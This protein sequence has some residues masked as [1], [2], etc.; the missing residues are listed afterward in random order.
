MTR[1]VLDVAIWPKFGNPSIY[2]REVIIT[3]IEGWSWFKFNNFELAL[4][5]ALEILHQCGKKVETKSRKVFRA[6]SYICRSS[7]R[8][9]RRGRPFCSPPSWIGLNQ[10][11]YRVR[12]DLT[13]VYILA[14][15]LKYAPKKLGKWM[16]TE[17]LC[18]WMG[19]FLTNNFLLTSH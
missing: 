7:S 10:T 9:S 2:I 8:K 6:N 19:F 15:L 1:I 3:Y 16:C 4:G 13:N 17:T 18:V 14:Y 5:M 12:Q 11:H